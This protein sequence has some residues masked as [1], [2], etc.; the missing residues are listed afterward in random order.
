LW[1]DAL[2]IYMPIHGEEQFDPRA[3]AKIDELAHR[4]DALRDF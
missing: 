4:V 3:T 1:V 2:K